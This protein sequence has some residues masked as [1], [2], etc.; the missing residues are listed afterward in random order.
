MRSVKQ[1]FTQDARS[2]AAAA[3]RRRSELQAETKGNL[4]VFTV[5]LNNGFSWQLR[6]FGA[7]IVA[8]TEQRYASMDMAR[9]AGD[10]ALARRH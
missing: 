7:I 4:E 5:R 3:R 9:A 1:F 10:S 2:A 8:D 6:Q